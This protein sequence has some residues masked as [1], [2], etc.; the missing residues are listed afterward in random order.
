LLVITVEC[1]G[2]IDPALVETLND[3][4]RQG[5]QTVHDT[6]R[7]PSDDLILMHSASN[8]RTIAVDNAA[9]LALIGDAVSCRIGAGI[10]S[11]ELKPVELANEAKFILIRFRPV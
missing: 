9:T 2:C 5:W 1:D 8:A 7:V 4:P 11:V 10:Y 6:W 3:D